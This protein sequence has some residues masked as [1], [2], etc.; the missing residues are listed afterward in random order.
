MI[1]SLLSNGEGGLAGENPLAT[2]SS[3][4]VTPLSETEPGSSSVP[5]GRIKEIFFSLAGGTMVIL[6][7][8]SVPGG[9][10]ELRG[11][12]APRGTNIDRIQIFSVNLSI[13]MPIAH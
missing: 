13:E 8:I 1:V 9:T 12:S 11:S 10:I 3:D 7:S 4:G 6:G 2:T 5:G